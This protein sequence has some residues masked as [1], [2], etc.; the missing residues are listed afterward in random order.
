VNS[1]PPHFGLL[2]LLVGLV[3]AAWI[4]ALAV[5]IAD[6]GPLRVIGGL[7]L[8]LVLPGWL[9]SYAALPS[10][11]GQG[12]LRLVLSFGLSVSSTIATGIVLALTA[13]RVGSAP[14]ALILA[15]LSTF[16]ALVV[17]ARI[18]D[19][20]VVALPHTPRVG[21]RDGIVLAIGAAVLIV[22]VV[23]AVKLFA[24]NTEAIAFTQL[25]IVRSKGQA[26]ALVENDE[27]GLRSYR[28]I[29]VGA[30]GAKLESGKLTVPEGQGTMIL[31][32]PPADVRRLQIELF[33]TTMVKP[34]LTAT[35]VR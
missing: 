34:F 11:A 12:R 2:R 19:E 24:L 33:R 30:N 32:R 18:S 5:T 3:S 27:K 25:S 15:S 7:A 22:G 6:P 28:W 21:V 9:L 31:L 23:L 26:F 29:I 1:E 16:F 13:G 35:Y 4:A 17:R 10:A 14:A 20:A 8:T